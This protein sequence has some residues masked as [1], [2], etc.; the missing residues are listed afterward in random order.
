MS[1]ERMFDLPFALRVNPERSAARARNL[2]WA[3]EQSLL[4]GDEAER[5]YLLGVVAELAAF[6]YPGAAGPPLDLAFDVMGW[7][8]LFDDQFDLPDGRYP[9]AALAACRA[10]IEFVRLPAHELSAFAPPIVRAFADC[11]QRM[12][13]GMTPDWVQRMAHM[14]VDYLDG[15]FTEAAD[16]RHPLGVSP[17]THLLLRRKTIGMRPSLALGE[18]ITR[19]E[20]P[21]V[22]W[23][24]TH[25]EAMRLTTLDVVIYV[26]EVFSFDRDE[27]CGNANLARLLMQERDC[28]RPDAMH[29]IRG[30]AH[31][32][33]RRF[34]ELER[35]IPELCD[36]LTLDRNGREAVHLHVTCMRDWMVGAYGWHVASGRY[37]ADSAPM[38]SAGHAG[39]L[40]VS[41]LSSW[42]YDAADSLGTA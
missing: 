30:R 33:V 41:D 7:F 14:W 31:A 12:T 42:R 2:A 28:E 16:L 13:D 19:A 37:T 39:M 5:R 32:D 36:A 6:A 9:H 18:R 11:W 20:V 15:H 22:A 25:L 29:L 1:E 26:N 3:R 35:Q 27:A 38:A 23:Y 21:V 8:F 40:N 17:Q 10:M 4:S 34:M 24:S